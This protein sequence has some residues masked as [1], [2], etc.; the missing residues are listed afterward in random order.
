MGPHFV[1]ILFVHTIIQNNFFEY[2]VQTRF[3]LV[4]FYCR[5]KCGCTS[6]KPYKNRSISIFIRLTSVYRDPHLYNHL[7]YE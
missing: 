1:R 2:Q 5:M 7:P 3:F 4:F 6:Y